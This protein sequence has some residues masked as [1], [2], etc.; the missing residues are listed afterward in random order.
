MLASM[1]Q[2]G[3]TATERDVAA[4]YAQGALRDTL[5]AELARRGANAEH[6]SRDELDGAD[7]F[8]LGGNDA[9]GAFALDANF[10]KDTKLID[11]GS[12]L[13]G[14]ARYFA[15]TRGADVTGIDLTE[16]YVALAS[17]LSEKTGLSGRTRFRQASALALPFE[18][19]AFGGGYLIHVA[20][21]IADKAKLFS[22]VRRVLQPGATFALYD[23]MRG[24]DSAIPYPMPWAES[25]ATSFVETPERYRAFLEAA[26]FRIENVTNRRELVLD[27]NR[28]IRARV[29]RGGALPL[30]NVLIGPERKQ[31]FVNVA[32]AVESGIIAPT[33]IIAKA[34]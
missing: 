24:N 28:E 9:T 4:H 33:Q 2:S 16:D 32:A 14:P 20:M 23:P 3:R 27:A 15:Q 21:N 5:F 11:I 31:R 30:R 25:E 12:G 26:G 1:D 34:V 6:L 19:G 8:H 17:E 10:A 13:G 29:E 22:E 7:E 18:D